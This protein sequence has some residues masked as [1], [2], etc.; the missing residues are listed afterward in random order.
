VE[1]VGT[2]AG[3]T[4][5]AIEA[6]VTLLVLDDRLA[7][8]RMDP[9]APLPAWASQGSLWSITRTPDELSVVCAASAVPDGVQAERGWRCFRV[10]GPLDF[11][12]TGVLA[13]IA[14]PLAAVRISIF[15]VSTFDT[16]H[17][18]VREQDVSA[19]IDC[20]RN[21]GHEVIAA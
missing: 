17:I 6:H 21:A 13:S 20:L 3:A 12:L 5:E 7:V 15:S 11:S 2:E 4:D 8:A 14:G 9:G 19:A 10:A 18:L 16:D 1:S